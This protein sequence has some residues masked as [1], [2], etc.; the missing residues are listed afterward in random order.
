MALKKKFEGLFKGPTENDIYALQ[1]QE[2]DAKIRQAMADSQSAGGNFY[3]NIQAKANEQLSQSVQGVARSMLQGTSLAMPEDP[4]LSSARKRDGD[5][6]KYKQMFK[7]LKMD[8]PSDFYTMADQF[9]ADGY[10]DEADKLVG[11]GHGFKKLSQGDRELEQSG[12]KITNQ[13]SQFTQNLSFQKLK[14]DFYESDTMVGRSEQ[15]KDREWKKK[16]KD[17][18]WSLATRGYNI[19]ENRNIDLKV[20]EGLNRDQRDKFQDQD[21]SL[22]QQ[23]INTQKYVAKTNKVYGVRQG[24]IAEKTLNERTRQAD[25]SL[26]LETNLGLRAAD[27]KDKGLNLEA[28]RNVMQGDRDKLAEYLGK[29]NQNLDIAKQKYL[30]MS[31]NRLYAKALEKQEFEQ[32]L[33]VRKQ[34][35][36]EYMNS[37]QLM[38]N[39]RVL[40]ARVLQDGVVN[41]LAQNKY[42]FNK[43][44][45]YKSDSREDRLTAIRKKASEYGMKLDLRKQDFTE[46]SFK[47]QENRLENRFNMEMMFKEK[48]LTESGKIAE[49]DAILRQAGHDLNSLNSKKKW[50]LAGETLAQDRMLGL[51][52]L[53]MQEKRLRLQQ[54]IAADG[55]R[56]Q[57]NAQVLKN[58]E[59]KDLKDF[60]LL[61]LQ[62]KEA[63]LAMKEKIAKMTIAGR[64]DVAR[65]T[66]EARVKKEALIPPKPAG[67]QDRINIGSLLDTDPKLNASFEKQ[68]DVDTE[69]MDGKSDVGVNDARAVFA[70]D[71]KNRQK[72]TGET[73][74]DAAR[75]ILGGQPVPKGATAATTT[76]PYK[77]KVS[78]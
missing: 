17:I 59:M 32:G 21:S 38:H 4:R 14:Q 64:S 63:N 39:G 67:K 11:Q 44:M 60:R 31:T 25:A 16:A 57:E 18:D 24:D 56:L 76:D 68:Y 58:A 78:D 13:D 74:E 7:N 10:M 72:S 30:E 51:G 43:E 61:Q 41:E 29:G 8:E 23:R 15:V 71:I 36:T 27:S 22:A 28:Q 34:N 75:A 20:I 37:E 40:D 45:A 33:A 70:Q 19:Q 47:Q 49:R 42:T 73:Q 66:I 77:G 46:S 6:L 5:R 26:A 52:G 3:A 54:D 2:R 62:G 48:K 1:K 69:W 9:R 55:T 65:Q 12:Q 53:G 50:D 35:H